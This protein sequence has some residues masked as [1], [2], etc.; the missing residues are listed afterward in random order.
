MRNEE[1]VVASETMEGSETE[2]TDKIVITDSDLVPL[3]DFDTSEE[4]VGP[5]T[6]KVK[7]KGDDVLPDHYLVGPFSEPACDLSPV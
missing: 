1:T 6:A 3:E 4:V 7:S 2:S 5:V